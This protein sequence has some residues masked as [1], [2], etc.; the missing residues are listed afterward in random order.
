MTTRYLVRL[1]GADAAA[2]PH[3]A[4]LSALPEHFEIVESGPADAVLVA[5][6]ATGR[7]GS[8]LVATDVMTAP[9]RDVVAVPAMRFAPRLFAEPAVIA[10]RSTLFALYDSVVRLES[11][12]IRGIHGALLE[13]LAAL[14]AL[15]GE[16]VH[17]TKIVR[18]GDGYLAAGVLEQRRGIVALTGL[19]PSSPGPAFALHAAN[20]EQRLEIEIDETS[21]ARPARVQTFSARGVSQGAL[22]HQ[23]DHR[24]TWLAVHA[25][26]AGGRRSGYGEDSWRTDIAEI[27][28]VVS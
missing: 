6:V 27:M 14:R 13:Q 16:T 21:I 18:I 11:V 15:T 17:L 4:V 25:T 7:G 28:A 22:N 12:K 3:R 2:T 23:N 19:G 9:A 10:A 26:L 8:V 1:E 20:V 24:L 5:N